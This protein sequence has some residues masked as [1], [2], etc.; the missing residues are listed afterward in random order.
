MKDSITF[1]YS[2]LEYATVIWSPH[3]KKDIQSIEN[4]QRTFT[5]IVF[6]KCF[7]ATRYD[8]PPYYQRLAI[9]NLDS[10]QYRRK[11]L[12]IIQTSKIMLGDSRVKFGVLFKLRPVSERSGSFGIT[13]PFTRDNRVFNS[14]HYRMERLMRSK[15]KELFY[16]KKLKHLKTLLQNGVIQI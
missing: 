10:L 15:P 9:L 8:L 1:C 12:D 5:R 6:Y 4:V 7:A 11:L 13:V 3:L 16:C 14:F 2:I